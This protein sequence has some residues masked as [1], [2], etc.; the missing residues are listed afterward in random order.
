M[1]LR[2][3]LSII[4]SAL[5]KLGWS[6]TALG[7]GRPEVS[8]VEQNYDEIVRQSFEMQQFPFGKSRVTLSSRS[9]GKFGFDDAYKYGVDVLHIVEVWLNA[10][11]AASD[12]NVEW[13]IDAEDRTLNLDASGRTVEIE[14]IKVGLEHTWSAQFAKAV[15][16]KLEAVLKEFAEETKEAEAKEAEADYILTKASVKA[17]KNRSKTRLFRLGRVGRAHAIRRRGYR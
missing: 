7:S 9:E 4:N 12:L 10:K 1:A 2:T 14:Y 3:K 15:Q 13:E 16:L 6:T 17:S 8:A 5:S 11:Y